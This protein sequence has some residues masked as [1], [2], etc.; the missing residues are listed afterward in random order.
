MDACM[1]VDGHAIKMCHI[2]FEGTNICTKHKIKI[3]ICNRIKNQ[4]KH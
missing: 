4:V 1:H 2:I 3:Q